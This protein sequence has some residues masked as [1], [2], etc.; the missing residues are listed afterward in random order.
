MEEILE[1]LLLINGVDIYNEFGAFL[2]EKSENDNTNYNS[3]MAIPNLKEVPEVS[4]QEED[5][6]RSPD[7][8]SAAFKSRDIVLQFAI[9]AEDDATFINRYVS[10][11]NFLK[12]G[13]NGWLTIRLNDVGLEYRVRLLGTSGYSQITPFGSSKV[14]AHFQIKFREPNPMLGMVSE[15]V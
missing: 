2:A 7:I 5:G 12:T 15:P 10:F 3:L 14:A 11:I 13:I 4:I 6:V 8:L 1:G 9:I